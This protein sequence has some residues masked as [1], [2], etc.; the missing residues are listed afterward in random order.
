MSDQPRID[1]HTIIHAAE[2]FNST[3]DTD[4]VLQV[5]VREIAHALGTTACSIRLLTYNDTLETKARYGLS[6][7]YADKGQVTI[8][9]SGIDRAAFKGEIVQVADASTDP[10]FQYPQAAKEEGIRSVLISPLIAR[11][12]TIG[13]CRVYTHEPRVFDTHE[14]DGFTILCEL[15]S[16]AI[17]NARTH[18]QLVGQLKELRKRL[19]VNSPVAGRA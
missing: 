9:K 5:V 18:Q 8:H 11:G 3:L 14:I 16:I 6:D 10:R 15:A 2:M 4:K 12:K 17:E 1:C 13:V 7:R 19:D